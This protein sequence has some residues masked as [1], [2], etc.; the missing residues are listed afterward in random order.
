MATDQARARDCAGRRVRVHVDLD[1]QDLVPVGGQAGL[2]QDAGEPQPTRMD[3]ATVANRRPH[4]IA[5]PPKLPPNHSKPAAKVV[6]G[7]VAFEREI[8]VLR[9]TRQVVEKADRCAALEREVPESACTLQTLQNARLQVLP[10]DV[11]TGK[12][13]AGPNQLAQMVLHS[14]SSS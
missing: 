5:L 7:S 13:V 8:Q 6:A 9:V 2:V 4:L 1:G 11:A 10:C 14:S 12:R 3:R